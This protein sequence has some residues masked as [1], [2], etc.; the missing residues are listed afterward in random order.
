[1]KKELLIEIGVEEL[2]AIPFLKELPNIKEKWSE[3]LEQNGLKCAFDFYYTP[4]RMVFFHKEFLL[5]QQDSFKEFI[6]APKQVALK[7]G[8]WSAAA[9]SFANKCGIEPNE[10]KFENINGKEV[11]FYKKI[12]QGR[13]SKEILGDI[14]EQFLKSLNF[15]KSMRWGEGKF[16]FIRPIRSFLCLLGDEIVKFNKFNIESSNKIFTHRDIGYKMV[17][18]KNINEYFDKMI[19]FGIV[20]D[21]AKR[22]EK[23]LNEFKQIEEKS[24]L[25]IQIDDNLLDEVV[26][27]TEYPTALLGSVE[28]EFLEIPS[29]VIITSMKENQRYFAVFNS[30][31]LSNYFVVISNSLS[32]DS[33]LII[34]GNEKV[35]RARLSDAMFFWRSDLKAEFSPEKLKNITYLK[36]L[37]S[38]YQKSEREVEVALALAEIFSNSLRNEVGDNYKELSGRAV[39]LSKADLATAMVYEFTELQGVM[40]GYYATA[41]GEDKNVVTAI[42]EQYLPNGENSELPSTLFSSIVALAIKL[43][44]LVGL[45]SVGKI[46]T[47][48]KDPYAL[49]RAAN[50]I[51]KI[52]QN[53][54][55]SFDLSKFLEIIS[56]KYTK[57]DTENLINFINERLYTFF[58]CNASIIK[59][60]LSSQKGDILAQI[61]CINALEKVCESENFRENFSTFKRLANIIKDGIKTGVREELFES[62]AEVTL[63]TEFKKIVNSNYNEFEKLN[64]LF[65]LKVEIDRFFDSVM[66][67]VDDD[68]IRHNR[69]A[70]IG[71][72]YAEFLKIADIK[73]ISL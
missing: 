46:P 62:E 27:I 13:F 71:E 41:K 23:I 7:N 69:Q 30:T 20:L 22:R 36:E 54:I 32:S 24:D 21:P 45:F 5:K 53:E 11:L 58:D 34:R 70:I 49:R 44:T 42:R 10:L 2:P 8:E 50:G 6:G 40:G 31:K 35:L 72:I 19:G 63:Y 39:M 3:I 60:A 73:E 55:L 25:K 28:M 16:E 56:Q 14:L 57:F 52:L 66:I 48:N 68:K 29:E 33:T 43:E 51:I 15:G 61:R 37:G 9:L 64:V 65:G 17:E 38:I 12:V 4:R 59:A 67:N 26:A 1:M 18:I 47:G